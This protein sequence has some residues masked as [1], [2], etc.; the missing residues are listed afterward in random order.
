MEVVVIADGAEADLPS[1]AVQTWPIGWQGTVPDHIG[2]VWVDAGRARDVTPPVNAA[3]FTP[4]QAETLRT[5]ADNV[6]AAHD[7][8]GSTT[9]TE[10]VVL[11]YAKLPVAELREIAEL[12]GVEGFAQMRKAELVAALKPRNAEVVAALTE[13]MTGGD[14]E[15]G[16]EGAA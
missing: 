5:I 10:P 11:E 7:A 12:I 6:N 9:T 2:Q 8:D 15:T 14:D 13:A 1:G 4:R 16:G 3:G